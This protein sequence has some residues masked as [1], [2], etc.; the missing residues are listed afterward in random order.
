MAAM[1]PATQA[2]LS[3]KGIDTSGEIHLQVDSSGNVVVTN[4]NSQ[5]QQIEDAINSDTELKKAVVEYL[6]FMQ[7]VV[8][9][10]VTNSSSQTA[11]SSE[12]EQLLSSLGISSQGTVTLAIQGNDFETVYR[13]AGNNA[14]VL[15]SSLA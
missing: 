13:D 2:A 8:P 12:L 7:A 9:S 1:T 4:G 14:V 15:A 11:S 3:Q 6:R 5:K 10:L